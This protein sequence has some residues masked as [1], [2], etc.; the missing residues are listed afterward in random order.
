MKKWAELETKV[1][2][3]GLIIATFSSLGIGT[4]AKAGVEAG[5]QI[6]DRFSGV[7]SSIEKLND[8]MASVEFDREL[9]EK[10]A[11]IKLIMEC[12]RDYGPNYERAPD[13]LAKSICV[14][15]EIEYTAKYG[16][17]VGG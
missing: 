7:E 2:I 10:K 9:A 16:T 17:G 13:S 8:F 6:V 12:K 1:K 4:G 11:L 5:L 14:N 3:I 15:A